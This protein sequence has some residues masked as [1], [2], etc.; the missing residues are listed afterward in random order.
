MIL[1]K[2]VFGVKYFCII[3]L[4]YFRAGTELLKRFAHNLQALQI[5]AEEKKVW[6]IR[7]FYAH[8]RG[9][10]L[11][12]EKALN[13]VYVTILIH[14]NIYGPGKERSGGKLR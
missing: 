1:R 7:H 6:H 11:L 3:F 14:N 2:K 8:F 10:T 9:K 5:H 12:L 4:C 13:N